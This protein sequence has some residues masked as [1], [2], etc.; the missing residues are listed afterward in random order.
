MLIPNSCATHALLSILLNCPSIALGST[1]T[2]L[3]NFT[4]NFSPENKGY[5]IGSLA[6]LARAH[7]SH[8]K[9]EPRHIQEKQMG[10]STVRTMETFHFV[11]YV[12][13]N[14]RLFELDGLK[15]Y[16]IDH[17]PWGEQEEWTDKFRRVIRERL[18][19]GGCD[20]RFNLMAVVADRRQ[21]YEQKL[22]ILKS[23]EHILMEALQQLVKYTKPSLPLVQKPPVATREPVVTRSKFQATAKVS[24]PVKKEREFI[25]KVRNGANK[26]GNNKTNSKIIS[27]YRPPPAL[28]THNY[29]KSPLSEH[30]ET[31]T[32]DSTLSDE[33][34]EEVEEDEDDSETDTDEEV[35]D[36]QQL[37]EIQPPAPQFNQHA[38]VQLTTAEIAR[39]LR[40]SQMASETLIQVS[41]DVASAEPGLLK[42]DFSN[43]DYFLSRG[44]LLPEI[45]LIPNS[46][47]SS[48]WSP[49]TV[50][51]VFA[52]KCSSL[53]SPSGESTDT[54]SEAGSAF[55]SPARST[56][57]GPNSPSQIVAQF[58]EWKTLL[59]AETDESGWNKELE[60]S[61]QEVVEVPEEKEQETE[62]VVESLTETN[63]NKDN[64][65]KNTEET[66]SSV[67]VEDNKPSAQVADTAPSQQ[68][69]C[70]NRQL[71]FE[72]GP[73]DMF[74]LST[75]PEMDET[76]SKDNEDSVEDMDCESEEQSPN[77][78]RT[79][80]PKDVVVLLKNLQ[81][82]IQV[83]EQRLCDE[84]EKRKKYHVD[85]CRRTHNY[86]PFISTFLSILAEQDLLAGLVDQHMVIRRRQGYS[87]GRLLKTSKPDK[88]RR[89]RPSL[90]KK[91]KK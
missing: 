13:I 70:P 41:V 76:E 64:V 54:A 45:K 68:S 77:C 48:S 46:G 61:S 78:Q 17:G 91:T 37:S 16:P 65:S 34:N 42:E 51:T 62:Q 39:H 10:I 53:P 84:T 74:S 3:K 5:A 31:S 22:K 29:A 82:E 43:L 18:D 15:P 36:N 30:D 1:L 19:M 35:E 59:S 6:E 38:S 40:L 72:D 50:Q 71:V 55:N 86:D 88:R 49:L 24:R 81:S 87:L 58:R 66:E 83:C 28:D 9:P 27:S 57:P 25:P 20:I 89:S 2:K 23:N 4:K 56:S 32:E 12:P 33:E 11:S 85:D 73:T 52:N 79:F 26:F 21:G 67:D 44:H 8:A 90:K 7:N 80:H 60:V 14:G 63:E 75:I 69:D 47:S